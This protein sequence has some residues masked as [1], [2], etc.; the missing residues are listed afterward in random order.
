MQSKNKKDRIWTF[1]VDYS[2]AFDS[3]NRLK[4]YQLLLSQNVLN[5]QEIQLLQFLQ[6]HQYV[7]IGD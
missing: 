3:V 7:L 1:F 4:L 6:T 2:N 5:N